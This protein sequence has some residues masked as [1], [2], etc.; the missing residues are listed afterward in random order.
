MASHAGESA[1]RGAG[2]VAA[3]LR[4]RAGGDRA[5]LVTSALLFIASAAGTILW[6]GSMSGGM[7]MPGGWTMSMAWMRM[8]GQGWSGA[9]ASFMG[10]W[11]VMMVAMMLPS[12]VPMLRGYRARLRG[13]G[14]GRVDARTAVAGASYFLVWA[15][16]G[17][18]AYPLG[19]AAAAAEMHWPAVARAVP[20]ATS[21]IIA[22]A[23]C[24]QLSVWKAR[25]LDGC[26][27][28]PAC[29]GP[30]SPGPTGAVRVGLRLGRQCALCCSGL[31]VVLLAGGVMDLGVMAAVMAGITV[32]R[33]APRPLLAARATGLVVVVAGA[34][35]LARALLRF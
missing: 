32:E 5:F 25:K 7:P 13:A 26:R 30:H 27:N 3:R 33:T 17:A 8:P 20:A 29:C 34:V 24:L 23:G 22:L 2:S 4:T 19:V 28:S 10:M 1:A 21:V 9:A 16:V 15:A 31:M 14:E 12:L 35:V 11:L 6:C 18:A